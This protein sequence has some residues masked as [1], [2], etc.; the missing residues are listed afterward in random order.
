[1]KPVE[2]VLDNKRVSLSRRKEARKKLGEWWG[3]ITQPL[4]DSW[5]SRALALDL[6]EKEAI[7]FANYYTNRD[8]MHMTHGWRSESRAECR[9]FDLSDDEILVEVKRRALEAR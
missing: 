3:D 8:T 1:M 7:I 5:K 4:R 9:C 2:D 6:T